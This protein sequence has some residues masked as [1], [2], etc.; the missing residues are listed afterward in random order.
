MQSRCSGV[1]GIPINISLQGTV[2]AGRWELNRA[3]AK[4]YSGADCHSAPT[5]MAS[6]LGRKKS[7]AC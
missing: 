7:Q 3:E 4:T 5:A 1:I 6:L 2:F